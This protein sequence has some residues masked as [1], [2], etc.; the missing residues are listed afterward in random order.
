MSLINNHLGYSKLLSFQYGGEV[1]EKEEQD[2]IQLIYVLSGLM[3]KTGKKPKG[4]DETSIMSFLSE[5]PDDV[6]M[7]AEEFKTKTPEDLQNDK[8]FMQLY[9]ILTQG[10]QQL[11]K[12]GAKLKNLKKCSCGCDLILTKEQ[13]GK[14]TSKCACN[15]KGNKMKKK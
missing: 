15:C 1:Q 10:Q 11:A 4:G 13:G 9:S 8:E 12:K 3:K 6:Q 2:P 5:Y 14:I 7:L